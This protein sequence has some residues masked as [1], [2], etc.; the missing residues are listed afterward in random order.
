MGRGREGLAP[1]NIINS[2]RTNLS[3]VCMR[4]HCS[5]I[6]ANVA[7]N[8]AVPPPLP[9]CRVLIRIIEVGRR[10]QRQLH[11][12]CCMWPTAQGSHLF[13]P[14]WVHLS[15]EMLCFLSAQLLQVKLYAACWPVNGFSHQQAAVF[16]SKQARLARHV[17]TG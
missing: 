5:L 15:S 3:L 16:S 2:S 1:G 4:L 6:V 10:Q 12:V 7:K 8:V 11:V 17:L 13:G 9:T 14:L